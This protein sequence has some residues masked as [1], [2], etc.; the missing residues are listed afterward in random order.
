MT[1]NIKPITPE[2]AYTLGYLLND[3]LRDLE[4]RIAQ[5]KHS[6][7]RR[8]W[9]KILQDFTTLVFKAMARLSP[10][11]TLKQITITEAL[12]KIYNYQLPHL[13]GYS[14]TGGMNIV[15][16]VGVRADARDIQE[17]CGEFLRH[18][19]WKL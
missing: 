18:L 2:L 12:W 16:G 17:I 6:K 8:K 15:I 19:G 3:N 11:M 14:T 9:E 1:D 4:Y 13:P 10:D 7:H 5:I